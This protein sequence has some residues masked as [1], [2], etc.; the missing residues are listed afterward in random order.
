MPRNPSD[1]AKSGQTGSPMAG[2]ISSDVK[3]FM[4]NRDDLAQKMDKL[5]A[6]GTNGAP[7]AQALAQFAQQN[8]V[9]LQRQNDLAKSIA[10][11]QA[12][13][14][15]PAPPPLQLPP[16]A[17]PQLKAYLTSR[18]QLRRDEIALLNQH[19][20]DDYAARQAVLQQWRQQ[21]ADR[22][23]QLQLQAQALAPSTP[24]TTK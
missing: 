3:E 17:S 6:Q 19:L 9:L 2:N 18:D 7:D 14:P 22:I 5:R 21:N 23:L 20:T 16:H 8:A 4:Q 12:M 13:N 11:K 24:S 10:Q 15:L 1:A